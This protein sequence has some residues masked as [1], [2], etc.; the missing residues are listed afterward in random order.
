MNLVAETLRTL[1]KYAKEDR[2]AFTKAVQE[3]LA[4]KQSNTIKEEKKQLAKLK[5]RAADLE[6]LYRK[7]YEDN[8]LGKLSQKRFDALAAQY[9]AEQEQIEK[10]I[11]ELE[12]AVERFEDGSDK[13]ARFIELVKRY[14]DFEVMSVSML[15]EFVEKIVVHERDRKGSIEA[16]QKVEI[17]LNFIG[18]FELPKQEA[19]VPLTAEQEE[20]R[21]K[22]LERRERL[23]QNYLKR[24]ANGKHQEW[25]RRYSER[26]RE[27]YAERKAALFV[28]GAVLGANAAAPFAAASAQ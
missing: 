11:P 6:T 10:Q 14:E 28:E 21:R 12:K 22:L 16:E 3:R 27:K 24:K 5:R 7:I 23:H 2:A 1:A 9:E 8:A 15:N 4:A 17:H 20:E 13:A 26:R 19:D 18:E 25:E